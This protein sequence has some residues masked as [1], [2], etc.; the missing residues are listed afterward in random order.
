MGLAR[1]SPRLVARFGWVV[2][3][4]EHVADAP[5]LRMDRHGWTWVARIRDRLIH[6]TSL[7]VKPTQ[8]KIIDSGVPSELAELKALS[9]TRG[10]DV[11]WRCVRRPAGAGFF[12]TGDAACV[13]DPAVSDGVTRAVMSGML[14]G[15]LV[16]QAIRHPEKEEAA[17]AAYS[18]W[19]SR[20]FAH[21]VAGLTAL[22]DRAFPGW[23]AHPEF[24]LNQPDV[25]A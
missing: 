19:V 9:P 6:W 22:Y 16:V 13:L 21:R 4:A 17:I 15:H 2:G 24:D 11:T 3:E 5:M 18:D 25:V 10:A 20:T 7:N 23:R 14:A 8:P 12:V 1:R